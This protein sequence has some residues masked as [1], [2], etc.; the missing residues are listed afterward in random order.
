MFKVNNWNIRTRCETCSK[1]TIKTYWTYFIPCSSDSIVNFEKVNVDWVTILVKSYIIDVWECS[2]IRLWN[3][4]KKNFLHSTF[5]VFV[6]L[7]K[8][9]L[10]AD[11]FIDASALSKIFLITKIPFSNPHQQQPKVKVIFTRISRASI[12][13]VW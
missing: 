2:K 12:E 1:W 3:S 6:T 5:L 13:Q 4:E 7:Q 10:S 8:L 9:E 11:N